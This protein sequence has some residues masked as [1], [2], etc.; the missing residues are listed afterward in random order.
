MTCVFFRVYEEAVSSKKFDVGKA[1]SPEVETLTHEHFLEAVKILKQDPRASRRKVVAELQ[2]RIKHG[3]P[4]EEETEIS[5]ILGLAVRVLI[6]TDCYAPTHHTI[7]YTVAGFKPTSWGVGEE[8]IDFFSALNPWL[9][10]HGTESRNP[11]N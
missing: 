1:I 3:R 2:Q 11:H 4:T 8:F 7:N 9:S 6:M 10:H 5:K